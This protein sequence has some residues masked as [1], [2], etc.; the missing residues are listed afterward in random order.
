MAQR[1]PGGKSAEQQ[2]AARPVPGLPR[3]EVVDA[4]RGLAVALMI[5]YHFCFDLDYFRLAHFDLHAGTFWLV[6]RAVIVTLFLLVVGVSLHLATASGIRAV[7]Y[8]IRLGTLVGCATVVSVA[9]YALFPASGIFFGVLHF[10]ALASVLALPFRKL[11]RANLALGAAC[12]VSGMLF[13]NAVFDL[14][15]AEW[16]GFTTHKPITEDYVPLFPWFGVILFGL[17]LGEKLPTAALRKWQPGR[18]GVALRFAGRRSLAIYMLHQPL[19]LGA[20][21]LLTR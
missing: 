6:S 2:K 15:W 8:M 10:I 7:P 5:A 11:G 18:V 1:P 14:P 12:I 17:F 4:T 13:Q 19:L 21:Y 20:L 9:S 3:I 16:I